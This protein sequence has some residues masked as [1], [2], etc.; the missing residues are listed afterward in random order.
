MTGTLLKK[1]DC[2]MY[3][4]QDLEK[5]TQFYTEVFG[6]KIGWKDKEEEMLG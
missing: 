2:V 6:L 3:C 5:A 1:I 4:V